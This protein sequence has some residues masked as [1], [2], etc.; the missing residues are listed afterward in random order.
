MQLSKNKNK[1]EITEKEAYDRIRDWADV[2]EVRLKDDDYDAMADEIIIAV[3]KERLTF[4]EESEIFT[5]VLKKP[6][7][8]KD[9][10][11]NISMIKIEESDMK[12]KEGMSKHKDDMDTVAAM[13]KAFCTDSEGNVI[14]HG[15]MKRI[16]DRDQ[17]IISAVILGFFVQAVPGKNS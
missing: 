9:G 11:G 5:Y 10:S 15:F 1:E 3:Q 7:V 16:K 14:E 4:D 6:I 13:F 17:G 12:A 2:L 8:K